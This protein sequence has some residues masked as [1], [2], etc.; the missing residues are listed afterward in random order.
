MTEQSRQTSLFD[1]LLAGSDDDN[2]RHLEQKRLAHLPADLAD[3]IPYCHILIER[4]DKA[5]RRADVDR[6]R[7]TCEEAHDLAYKING[8][9]SGILAGPDSAGCVLD[10]E[11]AVPAGALPLWG[12]SGAFDLPEFNA[13]VE[14][15]GFFGVA[16]PAPGFAVRVYVTPLFVAADHDM[17]LVPAMDPARFF[18]EELYG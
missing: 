4:F 2:R 3:G 14:F 7:Q 8:F 15:D 16:A 10:R 9:K 11:T 12:Q 6:A 13:R 5:M 18:A 17:D 1:D